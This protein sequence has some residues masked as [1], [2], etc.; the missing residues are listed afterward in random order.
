MFT[1]GIT[2]LVTAYVLLALLL[3]SVN[4]YSSWSWKIKFGSILL[5]TFFYAVTYLSLPP[6]LG[7]PTGDD[8]PARLR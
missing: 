1:L 5:V 8:P 3:L 6:L 2:G 7:W 4:L